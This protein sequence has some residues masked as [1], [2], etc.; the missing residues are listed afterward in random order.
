MAR[1]LSKK[2]VLR[3]PLRQDF[4]LAMVT[5]EVAAAAAVDEDMLRWRVLK[6]RFRFDLTLPMH[7]TFGDDGSYT[8][9]AESD[10]PAEALRF[11]NS[12][13][14]PCRLWWMRRLWLASANADFCDFGS[15]II[16]AL[17]FIRFLENR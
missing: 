13:A 7:E 4:C 15:P 17:D 14:F 6:R 16:A 8:T 3:L 2:P 11:G 10:F 5:V 1:R 12:L 9:T